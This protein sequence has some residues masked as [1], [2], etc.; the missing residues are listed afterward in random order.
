MAGGRDE[1]KSGS[2]AIWPNEAHNYY[3]IKI[4]RY[5]EQEIKLKDTLRFL[6]I[7]YYLRKVEKKG[8]FFVMAYRNGG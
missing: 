4:Y 5:F 7:I 8:M 6:F 2:L 1:F 3:V